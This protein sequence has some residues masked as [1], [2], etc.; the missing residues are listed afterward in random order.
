[1]TTRPAGLR[2]IG[3]ALVAS[4]GSV[5]AATAVA[6]AGTYTGTLPEP[7]IAWISDGSKPAPMPEASMHNTHKSFVPEMIVIT[8]GTNVRFPNDDGFYH[9]IYSESPADPFDIGFYD[10]GPGK[11]VAF[12]NAGVDDVRCHIHGS[13]HGVIVIVDGPYAQTNAPNAT[14]TL[15][16][17]RPG[18]HTLHVWTPDGGEKTSTVRVAP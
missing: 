9:S 17:V 4:A 12:P 8:A 15:T 1:M 13:M 10:T 16:N 11:I 5:L 2:R 14:Y 6:F 7:G 3:A 18:E